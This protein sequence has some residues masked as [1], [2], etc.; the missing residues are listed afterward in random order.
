V[1]DFGLAKL[2][3]KPEVEAVSMGRTMTLEAQLTS[4]GAAIGTIAYIF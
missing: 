3:A 1:F 4:P 2:T